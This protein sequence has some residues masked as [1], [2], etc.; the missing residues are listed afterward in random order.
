MSEYEMEQLVADYGNDLYRFCIHL[1]GSIDQAEDLYQDTFVK[2]IQLR[3]K[4]NRDGNIKS[5]LMGIALNLWKNQLRKE[6][7]RTSLAPQADFE[8]TEMFITDLVDDPL[9]TYLDREMYQT[10]YEEV[11][12]LPEKQRI[13]IL[14]YYSQELSVRE[15]SHTLHIPKGTV[16]SRLASARKK[17]KER[18]EGKDDVKG[19]S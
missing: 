9:K 10:L 2:V 6:S 17:L 8:K 12:S 16:L 14:L 15:I 1:T 7:R 3:H 4:L 13:V 19:Y 11:W 18:L 5:Y